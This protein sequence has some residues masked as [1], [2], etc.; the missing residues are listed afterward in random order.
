MRRT[1]QEVAFLLRQSYRKFLKAQEIHRQLEALMA[2]I[3][4]VV[5]DVRSS[6]RVQS[7]KAIST[8]PSATQCQTN[9]SHR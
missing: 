4:R 7:Q 9:P 5:P 8:N 1:R 3:E 2:Q 6:A